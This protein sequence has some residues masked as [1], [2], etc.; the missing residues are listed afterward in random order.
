ML[1][2]FARNFE[3]SA[4][5]SRLVA[6][7]CE[8]CGCEYLFELARV[9]SGRAQ[10][11][12][13]IG[14]KRAARA[15]N[16]RAE[17]DLAKR[18]EH[19]AELVPCPKCAWINEDLVSRYRRGRYRGWA[20]FAACIVILGTVTSL[21]GAWF[22]STGPAADRAAAVYL[23]IL[24]PTISAAVAT[25]ALLCRYWL[26]KRI[27][28]NRDY[29]L[30]P[31]LPPGV[32]TPLTKHPTTGQ[33]DVAGSRN[34]HDDAT[35]QWIN[36]QIGR[37][38]LPSLCCG[39]QGASEAQSAYRHPVFRAAVLVVPLCAR[40]AREWTVR[41]WLVGLVAFLAVVA[42]ALLLLTA[43]TSDQ[44]VCW[45]VF[46]VICGITPLA[47]AGLA[48]R[49]TTPVRVRSVDASRAMVRLWFRNEEYRNHIAL[50]EGVRA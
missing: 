5:G 28:P 45:L 20:K 43:L 50:S 15:A 29:P 25:L 32:P 24:G 47:C 10:A 19:D 37:Q 8:K 33:V 39:C 6:V 49:L 16:E 35:G 18:L 17:R 4:V 12:Y 48:F 1:F 42:S 44:L 40:C 9:G 36:F 14:V 38:E 34:V 22:V 31:K 30:P 7:Q 13:G 2:Y 21:I 3:S 27:Q 41:M 11:A 23:S 46:G 26:R